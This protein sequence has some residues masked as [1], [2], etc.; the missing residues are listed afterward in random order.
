MQPQVINKLVKI[1][2]L[3]A[4]GAGLA[5]CSGPSSRGAAPI[6]ERPQPPSQGLRIHYV[7]SG[8]TLY[9]IAFRYE[10][11]FRELASI[12]G[13]SN[14][15]VIHSGQRLYLTPE[16]ARDAGIAPSS[17]ISALPPSPQPRSLQVSSSTTR[18]PVASASASSTPTSLPSN[19]SSSSNAAS[20]EN[21]SVAVSPVLPAVTP[22]NWVW[23]QNGSIVRSFG[24]GDPVSKGIQIS[25]PL[26]SPV[27]AA[28]DGVV[29]YSGAGL[30]GYGNLLIVKHDEEHLSAYAYNQQLLAKEGDIVM[31]GQQIATVGTDAEG[32]N[33]LYFEIRLDG[34]PVDPIRY[35]PRR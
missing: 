5:A 4:L 19:N 27:N 34:T 3:L 8:E 22:G 13:L 12:N 30:R 21:T 28:I 6:A 2:F 23:P 14:D 1:L 15:Y 10:R 20:S 32:N 35:L 11:D 31:A 7:A 18:V 17:S 25:A 26:G 24:S 16:A 33:R 29:V 9:S